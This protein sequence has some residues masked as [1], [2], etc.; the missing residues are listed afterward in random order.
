[1]ARRTL[2]RSGHAWFKKAVCRQQSPS[3]PTRTAK[4]REIDS[5]SADQP[6]ATRRVGRFKA[7]AGRALP[8]TGRQSAVTSR[9]G[10]TA[11]GHRPGQRHG[12]AADPC[13]IGEVYNRRRRHS[14]FGRLSPTPYKEKQPGALSNRRLTSVQTQGPPRQCDLTTQSYPQYMPSVGPVHAKRGTGLWAGVSN[15][16]RCALR[17]RGT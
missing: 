16:R 10:T 4:R 12:R 8:V 17:C 1:M 9:E 2:R 3:S 15:D 13:F 7:F 5:S 11:S 14:A 6:R